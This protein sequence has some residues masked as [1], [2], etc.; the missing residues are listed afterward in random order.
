[1]IAQLVIVPHAPTVRW[2][3]VRQEQ[4]QRLHHP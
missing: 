4:A 2:E 1:V 3:I